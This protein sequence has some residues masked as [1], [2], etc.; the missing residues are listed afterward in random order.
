MKLHIYDLHPQEGVGVNDKHNFNTS[1]TGVPFK[2]QS[3]AK[4]GEGFQFY[5]NKCCVTIQLNT[6]QDKIIKVLQGRKQ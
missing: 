2:L 1:E 3:L 4:L 6:V 5:V